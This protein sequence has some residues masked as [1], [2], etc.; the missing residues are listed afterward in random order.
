MNVREMRRSDTPQVAEEMRINFGEE[1]ALKGWDPEHFTRIVDRSFGFPA[2][3][4]LFLLRLV[5]RSPVHLFVAEEGGKVVGTT[6]LFLQKSH[7]YVGAVMTDPAFRGRGFA[8][9][10]LQRSED[11]CRRRRRTWVV[12]DVLQGNTGARNLYLQRGYRPLRV[13]HWLVRPLGQ[14]REAFR[15]SAPGIRPMEK[16]DLGPLLELYAQQ[17][18]PEVRRVL[19]PERSHIAPPQY[20]QSMMSASSAAWC[21]GPVGAPTGYLRATFTTP[22]QAGNISAPLLGA[23]L[24][25]SER[26]AL[27][28]AGL[29]W[30]AA[31]GA[32]R[33][34][35]EVPDYAREAL[36]LLHE[37][38]FEERWAMDT[39]LLTLS[40][41][42][43]RA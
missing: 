43:A 40:E 29:S 27:L 31:Q 33:V 25:P 35:T 34:V 20:L 13:Q 3:T 16:K 18:P 1:L 14:G 11:A 10:L 4:L 26:V 28:E 39:L 32:P 7:G 8:S 5:R 15:A 24:P 30:L 23:H 6:F 2:G 17:Q 36:A 38:G 19:A 21:T 42:N 9:T 22:K 41:R 37:A 12:L